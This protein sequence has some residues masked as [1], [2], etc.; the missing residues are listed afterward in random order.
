VPR[1]AIEIARQRLTPAYFSR[2]VMTAE[3]FGPAEAV[4][5]GFFDRV[6]PADALERS[7]AEAALTLGT[8]NMAAHAATKARARGAV[9]NMIRPM[10]DEDI[11][12]QYGEDRVRSRAQA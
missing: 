10:I 9:I 11:T 3:M 6:V 5:A 7:A 1:F 4:T 12:S 2:V 8:L